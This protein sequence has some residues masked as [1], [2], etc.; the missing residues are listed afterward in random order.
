MTEITAEHLMCQSFD[1]DGSKTIAKENQ[2][3][4]AFNE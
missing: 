2:P 4:D 1:A 3:N